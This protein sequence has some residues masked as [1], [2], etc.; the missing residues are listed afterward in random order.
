MGKIRQSK[1]LEEFPVK[2]EKARFSGK[3]WRR[4]GS[5]K[6]KGEMDGTLGSGGMCE[7]CGAEIQLLWDAQKV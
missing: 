7:K 3:E 2:Q 4:K 6:K 5:K 1:K